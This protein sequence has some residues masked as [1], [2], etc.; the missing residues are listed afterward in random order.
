MQK[1]IHTE[2]QLYKK[3]EEVKKLEKEVGR[4][5][6]LPSLVGKKVKIARNIIKRPYELAYIVENDSNTKDYKV[7]FDENWHGYFN[8]DELIIGVGKDQC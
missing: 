2:A 4:L 3:K 7:C 6:D 8:S 5:R 1:L